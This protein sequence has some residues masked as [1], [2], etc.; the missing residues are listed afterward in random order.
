MIKSNTTIDPTQSSIVVVV[1]VSGVGEK[2]SGAKKKNQVGTRR[3]QSYNWFG[4]KRAQVVPSG[5]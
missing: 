5:L 2:I 4:G 3:T 1:V